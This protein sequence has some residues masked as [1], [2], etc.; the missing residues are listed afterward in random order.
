MY[1]G[2]KRHKR[3][4]NGIKTVF[5]RITIHTAAS[6]Q[7]L[8]LLMIKKWFI[9]SNIFRSKQN[10]LTN[11]HLQWGTQIT[12]PIERDF[13]SKVN[14]FYILLHVKLCRIQRRFLKN[15]LIF[16]LFIWITVFQLFTY[17]KTVG[18]SRADEYDNYTWVNEP[19]IICKL[20]QHKQ[21]HRLANWL[22]EY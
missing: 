11:L 4:K 21:G 22:F 12:R 18:H 9:N 20:R 16:G 19:K 5:L 17:I 1:I 7:W 3:D 2:K 14:D 8:V 15:A 6:R 13:F 10:F